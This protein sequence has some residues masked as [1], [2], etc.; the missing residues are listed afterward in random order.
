MP[1]SLRVREEERRRG[2]GGGGGYTR[3]ETEI[4]NCEVLRSQGGSLAMGGKSCA[5]NALVCLNVGID[6]TN[7]DNLSFLL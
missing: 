3:R 7:I 1:R 6:R 4:V 5:E 2:G